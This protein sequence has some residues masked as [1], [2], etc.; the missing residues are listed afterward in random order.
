MEEMKKCTKCGEVKP[1]SEF[2]KKKWK[3]KNNITH[4][5]RSI[6]KIC[7]DKQTRI[8]Q[9][10]LTYKKAK[11]CDCGNRLFGQSA[12]IGMCKNCYEPIARD[13]RKEYSKIY[14][15][16]K[17][18]KLGIM[19]FKYKYGKKI[20]MKKYAIIYRK[21]NKNKIAIKRKK[22]YEINKE[23][24]LES[25]YYI[26]TLITNGTNLTKSDIPQ[27]LVDLKRAIIKLN[28]LT[29]GEPNGTNN[30]GVRIENNPL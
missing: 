11:F 9:K 1:L 10:K 8:N 16:E 28:R 4:G 18:R 22:Y 19:P 12:K 24:I 23:K 25:D 2:Y 6:C 20:I 30:V 7:H 21:I 14:M 3:Y 15:M 27:E 29:K 26:K 17:R 5:Y 13:K